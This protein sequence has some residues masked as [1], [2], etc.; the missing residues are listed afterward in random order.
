MSTLDKVRVMTDTSSDIS[1]Q[2]A[3]ELGICLLPVGITHRG[4]FYREAYDITKRDFWELLESS[5]EIAA[6][7]QVQPELV[8]QAFIKARE[9]GCTGA[10]LVTINSEASGLY[11]NALITRELFYEEY[12]S[13]MEIVI[14]DSHTFSF[15][16]GRPVMLAAELS[17]RG[18]SLD[19]VVGF[20]KDRLSKVC[21]YA[22][23]YTLKYSSKSGRIKATTA[24]LGEMLGVKPILYLGNSGAYVAEKVRGEAGMI[25]KLIQLVKEKAV[26]IEQQEIMV[27]T[28]L[29]DESV[30]QEIIREAKAQLKPASVYV[31]DVGCSISNNAGPRIF[32]ILFY[33]EDNG[34]YKDA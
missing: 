4:V 9:D 13:D 19:A 6:T 20:L 25:P 29:I 10:V 30:K 2:Q 24:V 7:S 22:P 26:N 32:G 34:Y 1:L 3:E 8:R 5:G 33:A 23:M 11:Q 18:E 17:A 16:Y 31:D 14:L 12:G 21:G 27:I 15:L 28:G